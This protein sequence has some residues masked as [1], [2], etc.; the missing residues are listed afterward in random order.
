[1][2]TDATFWDFSLHFYAQPGVAAACLRCQDEAAA[3]VNLLLFALWHAASG[4]C[5]HQDEISAADVAVA[6]WRDH[7]IK[8]LRSLRRAL[9]SPPLATLEPTGGFRKQV[10]ALELE[11]EHVEQ[12]L[13]A[14]SLPPRPGNAA[15]R[16]TARANLGAYAAASGITLPEDAVATLLAAFAQ[17]TVS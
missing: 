13:L 17:P 10:Q 5:L 3:D 1:M 15:S 16:E 11:C 7:V 6:P 12:P 8:P 4:T 9:K 2:G 14:R